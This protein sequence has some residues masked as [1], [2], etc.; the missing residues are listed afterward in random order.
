MRRMGSFQGSTA[1]GISPIFGANVW[2]QKPRQRRGVAPAST[3]LLLP[4]VARLFGAVMP[5]NTTMQPTNG[6]SQFD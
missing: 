2:M 5:H 3:V 4:K 1:F 6:A